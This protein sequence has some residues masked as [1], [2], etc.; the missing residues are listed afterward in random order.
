MGATLSQCI[1]GLEPTPDMIV[2]IE[3]CPNS[4]FLDKAEHLIKLLKLRS[5]KKSKEESKYVKLIITTDGISKGMMDVFLNDENIFS[6]KAI[7]VAKNPQPRPSEVGEIIGKKIHIYMLKSY[8][9][10]FSL[11]NLC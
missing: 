5:E 10:Y 4:S 3:Y 1:P 8:T 2:R 9:I 11:I 7:S 6:K